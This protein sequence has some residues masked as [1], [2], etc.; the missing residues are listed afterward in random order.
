FTGKVNGGGLVLAGKTGTGTVWEAIRV[1]CWS[2][3]RIRGFG[4]LGKEQLHIGRSGSS[5]GYCSGGGEVIGKA[6]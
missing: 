2:T 4:Q 3:N 5:H 1:R 6:G